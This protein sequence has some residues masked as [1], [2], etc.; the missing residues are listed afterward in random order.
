MVSPQ[1]SAPAA[2]R[3]AA[4][5]YVV[6]L[7]PKKSFGGRSKAPASGFRRV[8]ERGESFHNGQTREDAPQTCLGAVRVTGS[9]IY[10]SEITDQ[11]SQRTPKDS[12][13]HL[14]DANTS[15]CLSIL[16]YCRSVR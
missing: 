2:H 13:A 11:F 7:P 14:Q 8:A 16:G 5:G 9:F 15:E 4:P 10:Q 12:A 3:A 6:L 1:E